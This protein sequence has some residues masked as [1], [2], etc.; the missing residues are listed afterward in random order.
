[1]AFF[2][3]S[4]ALAFVVEVCFKSDLYPKTSSVKLCIRARSSALSEVKEATLSLYALAD[5][6]ELSTELALLARSF[7]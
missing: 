4:L 2:S 6:A 7:M 3:L 1:M 5:L